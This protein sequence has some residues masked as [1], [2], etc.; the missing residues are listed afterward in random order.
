M[1]SARVPFIAF[2]PASLIRPWRSRVEGA[3]PPPV[4]R[5][6]ALHAPVSAPQC[7]SSVRREVERAAESP[8]GIIKSLS[9]E[10]TAARVQGGEL[11][12]EPVLMS[13]MT[14][15]IMHYRQERSWGAQSRNCI[16]FS[17]MA[18]NNDTFSSA[19]EK[20]KNG[21]YCPRAW[22][23]GGARTRTHTR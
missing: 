18:T 19:G 14:L 3:E 11:W 15:Q 13:F 1:S 4:S 22:G 5:C 20:D 16:D 9:K 17:L 10:I 23:R 12:G 21:L 8:N 2:P 7:T 6:P